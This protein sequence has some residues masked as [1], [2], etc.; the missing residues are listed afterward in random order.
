MSEFGLANTPRL[1]NTPFKITHTRLANTR[2]ALVDG[3]AGARLGAGLYL[4]KRL[5]GIVSIFVVRG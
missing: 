3:L 1:K 2:L 5:F 4:G